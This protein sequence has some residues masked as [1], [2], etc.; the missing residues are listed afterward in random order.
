MLPGAA[1]QGPQQ[2]GASAVPPLLQPSGGSGRGI[3]ALLR[4]DI[5]TLRLRPGERLSE[6]ELADRFGTSRAPVRE[7]L[8]RLVEDG[9]IEVR[10]QRGSFVSPISLRAM[11]RARFV[12]EAL[13]VAIT[14]RA[15]ETG[16]PQPVQARLA[17]AIRAQ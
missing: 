2:A 5:V 17:E 9:L 7:A 16:L 12:R 11:E 15:A 14:R 10:P 3:Y 1:G 8:I 6:N 13:E 4:H